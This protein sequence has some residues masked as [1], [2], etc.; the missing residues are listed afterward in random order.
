[1]KVV[2]LGADGYVG[3]ALCLRLVSRGHE[4]LG[5]DNFFKRFNVKPLFPVALPA[6]RERTACRLFPGSLR[7]VQ[8][9]AVSRASDIVTFK[10]DVVVNLTRMFKDPLP[11][12]VLS[13]NVASSI[14]LSYL[15]N[16]LPRVTIFDVG[17]LFPF[18]RVR[19]KIPESRVRFGATTF[20]LFAPMFVQDY[21]ELA[22]FL[23][24]RGAKQARVV[25][26]LAGDVIGVTDECC[27][28]DDL[29]PYVNVGTWATFVMR[30]AHK[31]LFN[32]IASPRWNA[33][34]IV[35]LES[36]VDALTRL[37]EHPAATKKVSMVYVYD[38]FASPLVVAFLLSDAY[39][40]V[41]G[42]RPKLPLYR[43][44]KLERYLT[45]KTALSLG[46]TPKPLRPELIRFFRYL[47]EMRSRRS[48]N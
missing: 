22:C 31:L 7:L 24:A 40:D 11:H 10:P 42:T 12:N 33:Y 39:E 48:F 29:R 35:S 23:L 20:F 32:H 18:R 6:Q 45:P 36:L 41:T 5:V 43:G 34:F 26:V 14:S 21:Y 38:A 25:S 3:W 15:A 16:R 46:W 2:V 4:V 1:M 44:G 17:F 30:Y 47:L 9:D 27:A 37:V 28:H 8:G 13:M 19:Y